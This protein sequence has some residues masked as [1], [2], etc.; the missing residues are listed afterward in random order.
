MGE[1]E[2]IMLE[3]SSREAA[4]ERSPRR[5]PWDGDGW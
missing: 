1:D 5:K 2:S 4:K 3:R